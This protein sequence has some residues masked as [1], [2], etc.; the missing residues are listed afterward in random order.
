MKK[1]YYDPNS[2]KNLNHSQAVAERKLREIEIR[3][4]IAKIVHQISLLES[5]KTVYPKQGVTDE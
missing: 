1:S 2:E 4:N 3:R 5:M